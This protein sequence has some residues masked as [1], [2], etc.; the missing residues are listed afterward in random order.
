VVPDEPASIG[1]LVELS[2]TACDLLTGLLG[3]PAGQSL[4]TTGAATSDV[5]SFEPLTIRDG[6][7]AT[8]DTLELALTY[9]STQLA[10]WVLKPEFDEPE[11]GNDM[12]LEDE[13]QGSTRRQK[14]S[15]TAAGR[16]RSGMAG[17][18]ATDLEDIMRRKAK[19]LLK[20]S[21]A[22][23]GKEVIDLTQILSRFLGERILSHLRV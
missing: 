2:G 22:V 16:L 8:R 5:S 9:A 1:T 18:M 15:N 13:S 6:V 20:R 14:Q 12:D 4:G 19:D 3:R 17:A 10:M 23:V 21:E 7:I 11:A